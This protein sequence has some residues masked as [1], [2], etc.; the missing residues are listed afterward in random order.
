MRNVTAILKKQWKDT[1]KN[2]NVLI[3]FVMF[4]VLAVI[5]TFAVKMPGL[6]RN[7]FVYMFASILEWRRLLLR[8]RFWQKKRKNIH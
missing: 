6:P 4:P 3:Q 1:L 8:R 5:M 2:K 7:Y